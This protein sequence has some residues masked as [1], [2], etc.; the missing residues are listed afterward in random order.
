VDEYIVTS[1]RGW[2]SGFHGGGLVVPFFLVFLS[3]RLFLVST[4]L[5]SSH[6]TCCSKA[7]APSSKLVWRR[8]L[9][10]A[11]REK[12]CFS[13]FVFGRKGNPGNGCLA[14]KA[15]RWRFNV[16]I[17]MGSGFFLLLLIQKLLSSPSS[18]HFIKY[19]V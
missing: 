14:L 7:G 18:L 17:L 19:T 12:S 10:I 2:Q 15:Q 11:Q 4:F 9:F 5:E 3:Y 8:R 16:S 6:P 13:F 1:G